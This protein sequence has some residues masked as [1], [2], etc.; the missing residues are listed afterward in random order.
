MC[1]S[2]ETPANTSLSLPLRPS[3]TPSTARGARRRSAVTLAKITSPSGKSMML[4]SLWRNGRDRWMCLLMWYVFFPFS[5]PFC[6]LP[7]DQARDVILTLLSREL[8]TTST[9]RDSFCRRI[10]RKLPRRLVS[11]VSTS[12]TNLTMIIAIIPWLLS[13]M[14]MSNTR[15]SIS[16]HSAY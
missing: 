16:L 3:P 12:A 9:S 14:I 1:S 6:F 7:T 15:P 2:S 13:R 8:E 11:W 10:S 4:Q 5:F